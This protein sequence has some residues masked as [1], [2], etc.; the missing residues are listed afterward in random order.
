MEQRS[1]VD[2]T[3]PLR[4][5]IYKVMEGRVEIDFDLIYGKNHHLWKVAGAIENVVKDY[6]NKQNL[7][8]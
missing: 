7:N 4:E 5:Q 6:Y 8:K 3:K 1:R 2:T